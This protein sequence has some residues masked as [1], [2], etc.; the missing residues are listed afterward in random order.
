M[1][2]HALANRHRV[3]LILAGK[4]PI[5]TPRLRLHGDCAR[6]FQSHTASP[7]PRPCWP[8]QCDRLIRLAADNGL[9]EIGYGKPFRVYHNKDEFGRGRAS[10]N[11][12]EGS[13]GFAE[14]GW[15]GLVA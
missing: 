10:M 7:E 1:S 13:R 4:P 12:I 15:H 9:G 8:G 11:G 5:Q 6:R 3:D 14:P 2:R